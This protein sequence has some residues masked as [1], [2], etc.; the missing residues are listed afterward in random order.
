MDF[1]SDFD[2]GNFSENF[3]TDGRKCFGQTTDA[4]TEIFRPVGRPDENFSAI[5]SG[6]DRRKQAAGRTAGRPA[7]QTSG[8]PNGRTDEKKKRKNQSVSQTID[9]I[10]TIKTSTG[11]SKSELSSRGKRPF[12][13]YDY[14]ANFSAIY[15]E[16]ALLM[17]EMSRST[18]G[19]YCCP[20]YPQT[21]PT[22]DLTLDP[23]RTRRHM[24]NRTLRNR[25][26]LEK[27][28]NRTRRRTTLTSNQA[29]DTL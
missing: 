6:P 29:H 9:L 13:V 26:S 7:G 3:R 12:K 11:S 20:F 14:S 8:R 24:F 25:S 21:G 18:V 19:S 22:P 16:Q 2:F 17:V 1:F 10:M 28:P 4:Q 15:S 27:E 5:Y 23:N